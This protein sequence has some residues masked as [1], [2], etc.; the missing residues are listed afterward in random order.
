MIP[1]MTV[2]NGLLQVLIF[3]LKFLLS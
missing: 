2:A 1:V 3:P